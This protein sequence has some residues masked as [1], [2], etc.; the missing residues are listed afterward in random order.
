MSIISESENIA[1]MTVNHYERILR[2]RDEAIELLKEA[3]WHA[4]T[5]SQEKTEKFLRKIGKWESAK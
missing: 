4:T 3:S 1:T 2:E 5:T